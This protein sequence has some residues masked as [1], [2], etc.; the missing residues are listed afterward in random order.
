MQRQIDKYAPRST[1]TFSPVGYRT[2]QGF[3]IEDL[4]PGM[5][6]CCRRTVTETEVMLFADVSGDHNPVHLDEAYASVTRFGGRIA[7][8]MLTA[9][10]LSAVIASRLPGP[11]SIY[12]RQSLEFRAPVYIGNTVMAE[13]TVMDV[14]LDKKRV[15][16]Q[17]ICRVGDRIV[18]NGEAIVLVGSRSSDDPA[19]GQKM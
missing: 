4:T 13:V 3:R 8:G 1:A 16:L 9:S 18:L 2:A 11:G 6:A 12:L 19:A 10:L 17:T 7:H 15:S 5:T 14:N